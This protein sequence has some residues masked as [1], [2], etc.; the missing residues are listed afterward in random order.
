MFEKR[1]VRTL[2]TVSSGVKKLSD[3]ERHL[4]LT[5]RAL[6]QP[7]TRYSLLTSLVVCTLLMLVAV[8]YAVNERSND[9]NP[10]LQT[11]IRGLI[12]GIWVYF[13]LVLELGRM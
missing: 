13:I 4:A 10:M 5:L 11:A 12:I 2:S 9:A 1:Y 8:L 6:G 3:T 7:R